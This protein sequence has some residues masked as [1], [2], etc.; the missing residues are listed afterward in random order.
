MS[1]MKALIQS[2]V[3]WLGMDKDIENMVKSCK[4]CASVAKAVPIKFNP[5]PKTDKL[6]SRLHIDYAGPITGTYFFVIV[7]SFT[8]W[9]E[10]FKCK[11]P[12]T[13]TT[14]KGVKGTFCK[15]RI[16]RNHCIWQ[17]HTIYIK[18]IRRFLEIALDKSPKNRHLTIQDQID[19]WKD[20]SMYLFKRA[21]KKANG[22]KPENEELQEFLSFYRITLNL[23]INAN[24][25]P[26]EL[27]FAIKIRS[28]FDKLIPA[29]K[30]NKKKINASNKTYSPQ[31]KILFPKLS[32]R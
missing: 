5:W 2:Y 32:F 28:V 4:S 27:M 23:N 22:I 29:K 13:K 14:I 17:W 7:D 30:G 20:L 10:V 18:R 12:T 16:A 21:I 19:W 8:K 9:P 24:M 25:S 26:A 11:T 3:H 15:I 6:W 1:W 31:E